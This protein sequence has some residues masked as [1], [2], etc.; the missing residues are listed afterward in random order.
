MSWNK[1]DWL[2]PQSRSEAFPIITGP[3]NDKTIT[4]RLPND[5]TA[6]GWRDRHMA[7]IRFVSRADC[8]HAAAAAIA[9][10]C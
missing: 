3:R 4:S 7:A 10:S 1:F 9:A 2:S 5:G 6:Q 8:Y